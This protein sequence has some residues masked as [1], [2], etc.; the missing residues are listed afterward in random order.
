[1]KSEWTEIVAT[2]EGAALLARCWRA[3][4][5]LRPATHQCRSVDRLL[6]RPRQRLVERGLGAVDLLLQVLVTRVALEGCHGVIVGLAL[7]SCGHFSSVLSMGWVG[8][9]QT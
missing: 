7:V 5:V 8:L 6:L 4:R 2:F 9:V 3:W 1:M